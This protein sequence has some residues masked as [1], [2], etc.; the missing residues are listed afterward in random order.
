MGNLYY[1]RDCEQ[2]LVLLQTM[3]GALANRVYRDFERG[4]IHTVREKELQPG[5][6]TIVFTN[7]RFQL[8]RISHSLGAHRSLHRSHALV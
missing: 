2:G 7:A 6:I 8:S 1:T 4:L 3:Y 5:N